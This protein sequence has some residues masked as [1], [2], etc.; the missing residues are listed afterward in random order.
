LITEANEALAQSQ[1]EVA[2]SKLEL[3]VRATEQETTAGDSLAHLRAKQERV[4]RVARFMKLSDYGQQLNFLARD[5][6]SMTALLESLDAVGMWKSSQWWEELPAEDLTPIQLDALRWEVY[7]AL[8]ALDG[9]LVRRMGSALGGMSDS[10]MA[11][12]FSM[13]RRYIL[14]DAGVSESEAAMEV[15]R[16]IDSFRTSQ[17][18]RW[19]TA[20]SKFRLRQGQRVKASDLGPP[21]NAAD[22]YSLSILCLIAHMDPTF[23]TW[24]EGYGSHLSSDEASPPSNLD[25]LLHTIQKA[26]DDAPSHYWTQLVRGHAWYWT[27]D[28]ELTRGNHTTAIENFIPARAAFSRCIELRPDAPFAYC[29]RSTVSRREASALRKLETG[30]DSPKV[31]QLIQ[32]SLDDAAKA[33][34]LA[35]E[36]DWVHWHAGAAFA[37]VGD[38]DAAIQSFMAAAQFGMDFNETADSLLKRTVDLRGRTDAIQYAEQMAAT[39][40]DPSQFL[41]LL[42]VL[43]FSRGD[44]D[45]AKRYVDETL[46]QNPRNG[47]ASIVDG[48]LELRAG[49]LESAKSRFESGLKFATG[50]PWGMLGLAKCEFD[51][52]NFLESLKLYEQVLRSSGSERQQVAVCLASARVH[53]QE[54]NHDL[55]IES[56]RQA[57]EI[58]PACDLNAV[59]QQAV[60]DYRAAHAKLKQSRELDR[61]RLTDEVDAMKQLLVQLS[62]FSIAS[63]KRILDS[64]SH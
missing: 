21:E 8:L 54:S 48:W 60:S 18:T 20:T 41:S 56:I 40:Q 5:S 43:H 47:V 34:E 27:G 58:D 46:N 25:A 24:F 61:E 33:V 39:V 35:P 49:R 59:V 52:G 23:T 2:A 6:E 36:A 29:D 26:A 57:R 14:T 30:G 44:M 51:T 62:K 16:R 7:R 3:A 53:W 19:Y 31:R 38:H 17:V 64:H 50:N 28:V 37:A 63:P 32:S 55:A 22:G 12:T 45:A 15:G 10:G 4:S 9:L 13:V 11:I 42:A 1:Y